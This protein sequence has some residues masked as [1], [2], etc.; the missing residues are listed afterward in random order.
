MKTLISLENVGVRYKR[1]GNI[2]SK[3]S[4]YEALKSIDL[5]IFAGETLGVIGRNGAGK[6]TL[7][8]LLSG[9]IRPDK[10]K[11]TN[12]GVSV[13]LLALHAGFDPNLSGRDNAI[14]S[15]MLQGYTRKT[16]E[17]HLDEIHKF[18]E[19]G[20]F[21]YEPVRTYS[22]GMQS[23]LGFSVAT[24]ISPDVLLV[25]EVLGVGDQKFK[26]K[27]EKTMVAKMQS[28]QTVVLVSHSHHQ[29]ERLCDRAV[30]IENGICYSSGDPKDV[31]EVYANRLQAS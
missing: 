22:S 8:R 23:R 21:F 27:A 3:S 24:I 30:L 11:L 4:Y 18:S 25:D 26:Q 17:H 15:G 28:Q 1:S 31:Q 10:G 9:V 5:E 29:I 2:F 7:L 14:L 13:S 16:V 12:H 20:D 19:L 6:S